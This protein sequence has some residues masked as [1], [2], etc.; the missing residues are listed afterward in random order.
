M[1]GVSNIV[2]SLTGGLLGGPEIKPQK[3]AL[4]QKTNVDPNR[5]KAISEAKKAK[6]AAAGAAGRSSLRVDLTGGESQ[7]GRSG[8]RI[9]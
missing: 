2:G 6:A 3:Q 8:I 4:A 1:G 7:V 5:G 9:A